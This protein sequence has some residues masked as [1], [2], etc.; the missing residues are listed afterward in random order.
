M[1]GLAVLLLAV[2]SLCLGQQ[3]ISPWQ[4]FTLPF[5]E[6]D[7]VTAVI[8][9]EIRLPRTLIAV[10]AGT[11]LG[12][13]GAA[14]QGLLQNPL[15]SPGLVG[16]ASGAALGAVTALYFFSGVWHP[17]SVPLAG[18][19][20]ALSATGLVYLLAGRDSSVSTLILAGV[21]INALAA[22]L[23]SLLLNLA[24][25][26]FAVRE[27]VLWTLGD[28][29]DRSL[30]DLW[31]ML[32]CT[33][34]GWLL[35]AGVGRSLDALTLGERTARSMGINTHLTS[36][37][38]FIAVSLCV[39]AAVATTGMIGFI[40]LVVPHLL[41]PLANHQPGRLLPLAALGGALMLL[42][43]DI[44]VRLI[45]LQG[46]LPVPLKVGVLTALV[47]APFFLILILRSRRN[48]LS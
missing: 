11:S 24:P 15:A 23:L 38:I 42:T 14:M 27:L 8:I 41:R 36:W 33:L 46:A 26:P 7:S 13:S 19:L 12:L 39:G 31:L 25:S 48:Y 18:M 21:A 29:A 4:A 1:L 16:S 43:A 28:L 35:L 9:R 6:P 37:R 44:G 2:V 5:T 10:I 45:A 3:W 20:G 22:A 40:G 47:G 17:Q 34:A 30:H 32:P